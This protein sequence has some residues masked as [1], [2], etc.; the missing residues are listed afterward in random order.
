M[1]LVDSSVWINYFNGVVTD[2]TDYLH[3]LLG[4]EVVATGDLIL[5]EVLQGFRKDK[6]F[7]IAK[8]LFQSI[9]TFDLC[10]RDFAIKGASNFRFLRK[11]GITIRKTIDVI[12]ATFCIE[13]DIPLLY[14]DKDFDYFR[15]HLNLKNAMT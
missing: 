11:K 13:Y 14:L 3:S 7:Q 1:I 2:E 6:D 4:N 8:E 12:I 15:E 10:N 9:P 5:V